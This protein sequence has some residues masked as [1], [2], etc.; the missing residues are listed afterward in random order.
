MGWANQGMARTYINKSARM[1]LNSGRRIFGQLTEPKPNLP[2]HAGNISSTPRNV[3]NSSHIP[4]TSHGLHGS[5]STS[6]RSRLSLNRK[7]S[8]PATITSGTYI[9]DC[10]LIVTTFWGG[11]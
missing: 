10:S 8:A 5:T 9:N 6:W 11:F 4:S 2:F 7:R 3:T 1:Q